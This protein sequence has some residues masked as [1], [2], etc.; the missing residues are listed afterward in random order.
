M[1]HTCMQ[2]EW[3]VKDYL[4]PSMLE[5]GINEDQIEIWLDTEYKGNLKSCLESFKACGER[6]SG[7]WH[8]QDDVC[9]SSDFKQKTEEYNT[10][11]VS[12]FMRRDW[13]TFT[14]RSGIVPG[15]FMFNSFQCIRIPD[16][17]CKEFVEWFED[18]ARGRKEYW[19]KIARNKYD[20]WFFAE[21][22][23]EK[24]SGD[25]MVNLEPSIVDHIDFLLG[26]SVINKW[27]G[28]YARGDLW[29]DNEAFNKMKDKLA[30]R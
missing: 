11:I 28:H 25:L 3:Y 21:F 26:G 1:I 13:Q 24:H 12:G 14:P 22:I 7:R 27:R 8:L 6:G 17:I 23:K 16:L 15:L 20:D 19:E 18:D 5:Q 9:I 29:R 2:R 30:R 10:G 4:V